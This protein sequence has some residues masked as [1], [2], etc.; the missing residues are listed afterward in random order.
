MDAP[1]V[2]ERFDPD[3]LK[4]TLFV[5]PSVCPLECW[6]VTLQLKSVKTCISDAAVV[7]ACGCVRVSSCVGVGILRPCPP[8]SENIVT[9]HYF[10][11]KLCLSEAGALKA[12]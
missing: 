9:P 1:S 11:V 2:T 3:S 4:E 8:A 10:S 12:R 7:I 5:R 6:F